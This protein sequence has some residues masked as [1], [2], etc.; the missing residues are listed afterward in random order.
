[1][2]EHW[3]H[4]SRRVTL[5]MHRNKRKY[6]VQ[7]LQGNP[8]ASDSQADVELDREQAGPDHFPNRTVTAMVRLADGHSATARWSQG[9]TERCTGRCLPDA[10]TCAAMPRP[11]TTPIVLQ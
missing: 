8:M 6:S 10:G 2:P 4:S 3:S 11:R 7:P 1:M 9:C 5:I